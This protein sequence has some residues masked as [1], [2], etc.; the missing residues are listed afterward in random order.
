MLHTLPLFCSQPEMQ[1]RYS[2]L[3][4]V[5]HSSVF[6]VCVLGFDGIPETASLDGSSF[7]GLEE[8]IR[9]SDTLSVKDL[10]RRVIICGWDLQFVGGAFK[11]K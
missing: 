9:S 3:L 8:E 5:P 6:M 2:E 10:F 7:G 1:L 11:I 4:A